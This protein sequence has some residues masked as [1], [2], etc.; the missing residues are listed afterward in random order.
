MSSEQ[1]GRAPAGEEAE[2]RKTTAIGIGAAAAI[3]VLSGCT[4]VYMVPTP[5]G[6]MEMR[7]SKDEN[8]IKLRPAEKVKVKHDY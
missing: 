7:T 4:K 6:W 3:L 2:M 1:A 8:V 5:Q